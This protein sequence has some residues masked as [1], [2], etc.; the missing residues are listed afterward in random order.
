M[1]LLKSVNQAYFTVG[2]EDYIVVSPL[3]GTL[4]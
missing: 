3:A 2:D 4:L 1:S